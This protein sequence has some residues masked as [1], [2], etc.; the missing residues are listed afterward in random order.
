M[1]GLGDH[2]VCLADFTACNSRVKGHDLVFLRFDGNEGA[3]LETSQRWWRPYVL[4]A[5]VRGEDRIMPTRRLRPQ[6][7]TSA[8]EN[9]DEQHT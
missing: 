1:S 9:K 4:R 6:E 2:C 7:E 8:I 5:C 3:L